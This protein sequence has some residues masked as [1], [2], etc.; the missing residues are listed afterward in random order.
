MLL[1][2]CYDCS[3]NQRRRYRVRNNAQTI[4]CRSYTANEVLDLLDD[5]E[6]LQNVE[7]IITPPNNG[8]LSD[9]D[10][11]QEDGGGLNH[12]PAGILN[13]QAEFKATC[14]GKFQKPRR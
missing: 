1:H 4:L 10:S 2:A 13:A 8:D 5:A 11:D 14:N 3:S 9:E 7:V 6:F 12:L